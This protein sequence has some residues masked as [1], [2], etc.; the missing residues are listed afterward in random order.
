MIMCL[1][2]LQFFAFTIIFIVVLFPS[3][4][5]CSVFLKFFAVEFKLLAL[6]L[7]ILYYA[8]KTFAFCTNKDTD[9]IQ[10]FTFCISFQR[11]KL[12]MNKSG[13]QT[14]LIHSS[15]KV[16]FIY[17]CKQY[18]WKISYSYAKNLHG[19]IKIVLKL[20]KAWF[21]C[22]N[23]KQVNQSFVFSNVLLSNLA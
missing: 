6:L 20:A 3:Q 9:T 14:C 18:L 4:V 16:Q 12:R 8:Y 5:L 7:P 2:D 1:A 23:F 22:E 19:F 10:E 15:V 13:I 11:Q 21:F 17:Q